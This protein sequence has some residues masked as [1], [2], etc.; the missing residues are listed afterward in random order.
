MTLA[1][2]TQQI[3]H[4]LLCYDVKTFF[5]SVVLLSWPLYDELNFGVDFLKICFIHVP[6]ENNRSC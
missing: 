1:L 6:W 2:L 4:R 3:L 5:T